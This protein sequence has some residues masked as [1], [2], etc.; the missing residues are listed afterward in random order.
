MHTTNQ[1]A[2]TTL[3]GP[4]LLRTGRLG[5]HDI[6]RH[7]PARSGPLPQPS[8]HASTQP[9][10]RSTA[11]PTTLSPRPDGAAPANL[12]S[13]LDG[14]LPRWLAWA[15]LAVAAVA[16]LATLSLLLEGAAYLLPIARFAGL[17][18][19]IV[20]GFKLPLHRPRLNS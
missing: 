12:S 19:L 7:L 3:V 2:A 18:W 20:V 14:L 4:T 15:G 17:A 8:A 9:S 5:N 16:E 10:A 6:R 13:F 1:T 11:P